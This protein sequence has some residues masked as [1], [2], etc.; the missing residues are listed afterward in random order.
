[1]SHFI[2]CAFSFVFE[3]CIGSVS[4]A[5]H[6]FLN[7]ASFPISFLAES[8]VNFGSF[9]VHQFAC[10]FALIAFLLIHFLS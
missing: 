2:I 8:L 9:M 10:S 5:A 7:K 1:M 6:K 4:F 3:I